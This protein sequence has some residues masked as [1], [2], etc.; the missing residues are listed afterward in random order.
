MRGG[1][2]PPALACAALGLAL[3][4]VPP[5]ARGFAAAAL[6]L[7]GFASALLPWPP[8]AEEAAFVLLWGCVIASAASVHLRGGV[9]TAGAVALGL[10][11]GL[12]AGA[13]AA[14]AGS[15]GYLALALPAVL[16]WVPGA[17]ANARG[18]GIAPK[19][20]ASWLI[21]I[22]VLSAALPLVPTPG[23]MPDHME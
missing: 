21:A 6:V 23:Y 2:L 19:V 16:L 17:W 14:L 9:P 11:T 20:L 4:F 5:R 7:G 13:V 10:T 12:A 1:A 3:A 22:A 18:Y 8:R 15:P